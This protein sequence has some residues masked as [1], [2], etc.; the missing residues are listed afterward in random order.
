MPTKHTKENKMDFLSLRFSLVRVIRGQKKSGAAAPHS[1]TSVLSVQS[2]V[3]SLSAEREATRL[4]QGSGVVG[5]H[6]TILGQAS[7]RFSRSADRPM[8]TDVS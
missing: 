7:L 6:G 1:K 2:V 5:R 8:Q 3:N 4:R